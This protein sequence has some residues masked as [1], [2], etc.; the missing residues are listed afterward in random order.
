MVS[1]VVETA[2][3]SVPLSILT[4]SALFRRPV[5][6][7]GAESGSFTSAVAVEAS[8]PT[9]PA[10]N[11]GLLVSSL[12]L[13][14]LSM[15]YGFF[16]AVLEA[17]ANFDRKSWTHTR[18]GKIFAAISIN[19]AYMLGA[20]GL[21]YGTASAPGS[22]ILPLLVMLLVFL[23]WVFNGMVP[24]LGAMGR[25]ILDRNFTNHQYSDDSVT[26]CFYLVIGTFAG[27][28]LSMQ[29]TAIDVGLL[30]NPHDIRYETPPLMQT[31]N[32][33]LGCCCCCIPLCGTSN[34]HVDALCD[35]YWHLCGHGHVEYM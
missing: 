23:F 30:M 6:A 21:W 29:G 33:L 11:Q 19:V 31:E 28:V 4:A 7:E 26:S 14:W 13:S 34:A 22:W 1:K 8:A 24:M 18:K 16:S 5:A 9:G 10:Q 20:M 35:G 15:S 25:K 32:W 17:H 27:L 12:A 3:E 2:V